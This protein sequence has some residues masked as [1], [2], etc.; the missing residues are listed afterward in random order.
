M[1]KLVTLFFLTFMS[2]L[3]AQAQAPRKWLHTGVSMVSYKGDLSSYEGFSSAFHVGIQFNKKKR[4]NGG[5]NLGFGSVTGENRSFT[6]DIPDK[7]PNRF[8]K[9]NFFY[10]NY[11]LHINIVKRDNFILY[12]SQGVGFLRFTPTDQFGNNLSDQ[13]ET[14]ADDE[15]YRNATLM[16]PTKLGAIYLLPNYFGVAAE[17]GL[18]NTGT[19]YLDNISELGESGNDNLLAFRLSFFIPLFKQLEN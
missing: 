9:T 13:I 4:L 12:L 1:K 19:D 10:V 8:F 18:F 17:A 15:T 2:L 6:T 3:Q 5:F 14:R 7:T 11:D 16:A